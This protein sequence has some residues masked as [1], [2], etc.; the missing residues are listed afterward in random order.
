[1]E[2]SFIGDFVLSLTCPNGQN[3]VMHQQPRWDLCGGSDATEGYQGRVGI[4]AFSNSATWGTWVE[5]AAT[6]PTPR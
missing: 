3:V 6:G 5:S 4:T 2:H 1:M